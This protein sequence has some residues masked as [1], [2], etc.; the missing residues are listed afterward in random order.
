MGVNNIKQLIVN[1]F[2]QSATP[3]V[4]S[5]L[6]SATKQHDFYNITS[7]VN[8]QNT[9]LSGSLTFAFTSTGFSTSNF[10]TLS[11][12]S[13]ITLPYAIKTIFVSGAAAQPYQ[14]Q[15]GLTFTTGSMMDDLN[16]T[17]GFTNI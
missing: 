17:N 10:C 6:A 3:W 1:E 14:I 15:A 4:T 12:G 9:G 8:I 7:F 2:L 16:S 5:S 11:A 13:S